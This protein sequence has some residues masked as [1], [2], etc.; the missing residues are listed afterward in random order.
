MSN[1]SEVSP[2]GAPLIPPRYV[3]ALFAV[4]IM[5]AAAVEVL[6]QELATG[7]RWRVAC[8]ALQAALLTL[9]GV[10]SPGLRRGAGKALGVLVALGVLT[11][12]APAMATPADAPLRARVEY[13][14]VAPSPLPV[15]VFIPGPVTCERW[16]RNRRVWGAVGVVSGALATTGGLV[17][18]L[19]TVGEDRTAR[20]SVAV[21]SAV[22]AG[23]G[24]LAAY[25]TGEYASIY[26][27]RCGGAL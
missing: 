27:S 14:Q 23:L 12:G 4:S 1:P 9:P 11:V 16:D 20:V 19:G 7:S 10:A 8:M 21:S 15:P 5:A 2:T 17:S 3:P 13:A 6:V 26:K 18:A 25:Q 24:A 22:L